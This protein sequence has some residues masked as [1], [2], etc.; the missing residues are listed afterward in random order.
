MRKTVTGRKK[1]S[2][3]YPGEVWGRHHNVDKNSAI[4]TY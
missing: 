1:A 3:R 2:L 4:F